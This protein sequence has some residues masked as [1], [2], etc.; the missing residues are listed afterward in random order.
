MNR[1]NS[2]IDGRTIF[3][4]LIA[5]V[6]WLALVIRLAQ[7]QIVTGEDY[8]KVAVEQQQYEMKLPTERGFIYDNHM[9]ALAVNLPSTS[10]YADPVRVK[11]PRKVAGVFSS[12]FT[13]KTFNEIYKAITE[14]ECNF[15]WLSRKVSD[16]V[17]AKIE[18][19]NLEGVFSILEIKRY[20][21]HKENGSS[22]IGF[23]GIDNQGLGGIECKYDEL[24]SGKE[25]SAIFER[26]ARGGG[27]YRLDKNMYISPQKGS[28][29][30][31]TIN[32]T[33]QEIAQREIR[34]AY[35]KYQAKTCTM[36]IMN[37]KT[38]AILAMANEPSFDPNNGTKTEDYL[39][40]NRAISD[41]FEPGSTFKVVTAAAALEEHKWGTS[42]VIYCG[43]GKITVADQTIHD[44]RPYKD[45]TFRQ[46]IEKSS[47]IGTIKIADKLGSKKLYEYARAFGFGAKTNINLLG[48]S[49]GIF[50]TPDKWSLV[51]NASISI[52]QEISVTSLQLTNA[53]CA[54]AN[55]GVLM[56]PY[57]VQE[58]IDEK[59]RV[60]ERTS[61]QKIREVVTKTTADTL[62]SILIGVVEKGT[63]VKAQIP[64]VTIAGKTGTAQKS[65]PVKGG[66][67]PDKYCA[68]F[69]GFLPAEDPKYV[70]LVVIDEP[71]GVLYYGGD[72]A[73][74]VFKNVM[75]KIICIDGT[76]QPQ[77]AEP[78]ENLP[79]KRVPDVR[80]LPVSDAEKVLTAAGF[81]S[82]WEGDG[83]FVVAQQH[84]PNSLAEIGSTVKLNLDKDPKSINLIGMT[85][86]KAF[87]RLSQLGFAVD[88]SGRGLV[89]KQNP[90][91]NGY[92]LIC[93]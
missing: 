64:G 88:V 24:L 80:G 14:A 75:E 69:A 62:T 92:E 61:P 58:I 20:Y 3:V 54:I 41:V 71:Q 1:K 26:F 31:L 86:R 33:Y 7:I 89:R 87:A 51:S 68:S 76:I 53:F 12:Y 44:Y 40:K 49:E 90:I 6:L 84:N 23:T 91:E 47:N 16:N 42:D 73:A 72:I 10:F 79:Q 37:P 27:R 81:R 50:R 70:A 55:N 67:S 57:L 29:I 17:A 15:V 46:V 30:K 11:Q 74:P 35:E 78:E 8:K 59:G 18:A 36:I 5:V 21:P 19:M 9:Q 22:T 28:S 43:N 65:D 45:L 93:W 48:E 4:L 34:K 32:S 77:I 82:K 63:G 13:D 66:Y 83:A 38:G 56:Q 39:H 2:Y 52:G 25:G 60:V 85:S